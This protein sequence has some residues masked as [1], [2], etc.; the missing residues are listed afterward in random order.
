LSV[1]SMDRPNGFAGATM[2]QTT[3]VG[4]AA[5]VGAIGQEVGLAFNMAGDRLYIVLPDMARVD[6]Y[7]RKADGTVAGP[8][9]TVQVG[10]RPTDIVIS[11]FDFGDGLGFR[12]WGLVTSRGEGSERP[13]IRRFRL[14]DPTDSFD[15][16]FSSG[17]GPVSVSAHPRLSN[18]NG[19]I[20]AFVADAGSPEIQII[21]LKRMRSLSIRK[22]ISVPRRVTVQGQ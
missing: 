4:C 19:P 11:E 17:S 6:V 5:P 2:L 18:P 13:K 16:D 22:T 14:G 8:L 1:V 9:Q 21:D 7:N 20:P 12:E 10:M 15:F 3:L